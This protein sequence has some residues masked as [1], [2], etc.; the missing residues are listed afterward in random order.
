MSGDAR[1]AIC[2]GWSRRVAWRLTITHKNVSRS[3]GQYPSNPE[4]QSSAHGNGDAKPVRQAGQPR[5]LRPPGRR[6]AGAH[7]LD[8]VMSQ[9]FFSIFGGSGCGSL[10]G[11]RNPHPITLPT[12]PMPNPHQP[13]V[14]FTTPNQLNAINT[15]P[16]AHNHQAIWFRFMACEVVNDPGS[17]TRPATMA[18]V[19]V[20]H[21]QAASFG[22]LVVCHPLLVSLLAVRA[23]VNS[24]GFWAER[25]DDT[26][27][28]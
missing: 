8:H 11:G 4:P 18:R 22:L 3:S 16:T 7:C 20:V 28:E 14:V 25:C 27:S 6:V 10:G 15:V 13:I 21:G 5:R 12:M 19:G 23:N 17:A 2:G 9:S 26:T 1:K 24:H